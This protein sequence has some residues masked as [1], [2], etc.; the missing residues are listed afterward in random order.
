MKH[1]GILCK[2]L[3]FIQWWQQGFI[4]TSQATFYIDKEGVQDRTIKI[5]TMP[6]H[7][8]F[9]LLVLQMLFSSY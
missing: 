4:Y 6:I 2:N 7:Y 1:K 9:M 8:H 5:I 3:L